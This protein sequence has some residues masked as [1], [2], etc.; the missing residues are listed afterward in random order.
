MTGAKTETV[1]KAVYLELGIKEEQ[2]VRPEDS[3]GSHAQWVKALPDTEPI[4]ILSR[5]GQH[6]LAGKQSNRAKTA[7]RKAFSEFIMAHRSDT[8]RTKDADGR[9]HGA[10]FF[11]FSKLTKLK[12]QS[13]RADGD[14]L[15]ILECAFGKWL[16]NS[17]PALNKPSGATIRIWFAEDF[18]VGTAV[19]DEHGEVVS[20]GHTALYPH[21]SDACATCC[22]MVLDIQSLDQTIVRHKQQTG[23]AGSIERL[24]SCVLDF[25]NATLPRV[26]GGRGGG[27]RHA[28]HPS[29]LAPTCALVG[30]HQGV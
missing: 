9:Y 15:E 1:T 16:I 2:T 20:G 4:T 5:V 3:Q 17:Y 13:G 21:K 8:G 30:H 7:E 11:L 12:T 28:P 27:D 6:G 19:T 10:E 29:Q 14:E 18:G 26:Q 25:Y 22:S 24:V 23:S